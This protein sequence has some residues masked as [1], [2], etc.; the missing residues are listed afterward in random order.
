MP[1]KVVSQETWVYQK[2][3]SGGEICCLTFE[4]LSRFSRL[5][6]AT[7]RQ[8]AQRGLITPLSE[9]PPL[10]HQEMVRRVAKIARLRTQLQLNLDSLEVVLHLLDRM[11]EMERELGA[12]RR[13]FEVR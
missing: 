11:E 1:R 8:M 12:L 3:P 13:E 6:V 7:L 2:D 4:G 5:P 9:A 10:F